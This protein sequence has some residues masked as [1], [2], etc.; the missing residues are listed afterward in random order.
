MTCGQGARFEA[1][2]GHLALRRV[3]GY[4]YH[5]GNFRWVGF[6]PF[7]QYGSHL[8][9]AREDVMEQE[10]RGIWPARGPG[11]VAQPTTGRKR[12]YPI[13]TH[14]LIGAC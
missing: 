1:I 10:I 5:D 14:L 4:Y 11:C 8:F 2:N 9:F 6:V 7:C 3:F 13:R 12:P